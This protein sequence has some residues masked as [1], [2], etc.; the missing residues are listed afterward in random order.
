MATTRISNRVLDIG[1]GLILAFPS[2]DIQTDRVAGSLSTVRAYFFRVSRP[3]DLNYE[4]EELPAMDE[5]DTLEPDYLGVEGHGEGDDVFLID[6][7]DFHMYHFGYS[8][9]HPDLRVYHSLDPVSDVLDAFDYSDTGLGHPSVGD[10]R[11]FTTQRRIPQLY[12]PPAL[13]ERVSFR[14]DSDGEFLQWGFEAQSDL[15]ESETDI[16]F[17]GRGYKTIPISDDEM[18]RDM[19]REAATEQEE[20]YTD[21]PVRMVM[22]GGTQKYQLG[23][24]TPDQWSSDFRQTIDLETI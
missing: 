20:K 16:V 22:V 24:Q 4:Y 1:G 2:Q 15:S 11:Q 5:G 10:D 21:F 7:D 6:D 19:L 12:D 9:I 13:T 14:N 23:S 8:P 17:T 3:Q 18:Q